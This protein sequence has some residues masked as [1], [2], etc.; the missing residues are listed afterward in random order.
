MFFRY[1]FFSFLIFVSNTAFAQSWFVTGNSAQVCPS[2]SEKP[3]AKV[4]CDSDGSLYLFV[5]EQELRGSGRRHM[6]V[7]RYGTMW[8]DPN[9]PEDDYLKFS[10]DGHTADALG[11]FK[12]GSSFSLSSGSFKRIYSLKGSSKAIS[13]VQETCSRMARENAPAPDTFSGRRTRYSDEAS[14]DFEIGTITEGE[15]KPTAQMDLPGYDLRSGLDDP[16]LNNLSP[17]QC[18]ALCLVTER[19]TAYTLNN[20]NGTVFG[21][22]IRGGEGTCFLKERPQRAVRFRGV[23]SAEMVGSW[24][25]IL[26]PPT[27]G[28]GLTVRSDA[29]PR[30]DEPIISFTDRIREISRPIANSCQREREWAEDLGSGMRLWIDADAANV[31][32]SAIVTWVG[33]ELEHRVPVWVIVSIDK[34][35]RFGGDGFF[36]LGPNSANPFGIQAGQGQQRA[37]TA[38]HARGAAKAGSIKILPLESGKLEVR[39]QVVSYLRNCEEELILKSEIFSLDVAPGEPTVVLPDRMPP[40]D[41]LFTVQLEQFDRVVEFN[42]TR[43]RILHE[44]GSEILNRAGA[45]VSF[46][47]TSRFMSTVHNDKLDIVDVVDGMTIATMDLGTLFWGLDDGLVMTSVVPWGEVSLVSTLGAPL[48]VMEQV[49]GPSCCHASPESTTVFISLE[50][51]AFGIWGS[52]GHY[53]GSLQAPDYRHAESPR[54]ALSSS[55]TGSRPLAERVFASMGPVAPIS[56][57]AG[58]NIPGGLQVT[59]SHEDMSFTENGIHRLQVRNERIAERL[60]ASGLKWSSK[61]QAHAEGGR[62]LPFQLERVG[63][64]LRQMG[65]GKVV[66]ETNSGV[67][68]VQELEAMNQH[69]VTRFAESLRAGGWDFDWSD[70]GPEAT[71]NGPGECYHMDLDQ[72]NEDWPKPY[73]VRDLARLIQIPT[74]EGDIWISQS[75]CTAGATFG[76]L[77]PTTALYIHDIPAG[78]PSGR[79][80][81]FRD[82]SFFFEN[83]PYPL[84]NDHPFVAKADSSYVLL[85]AP[86]R[87]RAGVYDREAAKMV[88]T[89]VALRNG[90]MMV[91]AYLTADAKNLVQENSDGSFEIYRLSDGE[92]VLRGRI[93]DGEVAIWTDDFRYDATAE[94]AS[95][96]DIRF[97]GLHEEF[98]LDRF[99]TGVREIGLANRVSNGQRI[100]S[101]GKLTVP[102]ALSGS[103]TASTQNVEVALEL[104]PTR[105]AQFVEIYQEGVL[106]DTLLIT[107]QNLEATVARVKGARWISA[108][109]RDGAGIASNDLTFDVGVDLRGKGEVRGL[110]I[111]VDRYSDDRLA[112]LNYAKSDVGRVY[113]ALQSDAVRAD[114][115]NVLTKSKASPTSILEAVDELARGLN[116]ED[117]GV[118]FFAGHGL[119][120]ENGNFYFGTPETDLDDLENTALAWT[121]VATSLAQAKG[122]VTVLLDACH[123]GSANGRAFATNDDAVAGLSAIPANVTIFSAAKGRELS[124]ESSTLG[125]GAFSVGIYRVLVEKRE[126]Y[127]TN[128]NGDLERSEFSAGLKSELRSMPEVDQSPWMTNTR[129]VG[130]YALF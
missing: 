82:T 122:R 102:P 56:L 64:S 124:V 73:V 103:I 33:N 47:P 14:I 66:L 59:H 79:A 35:A 26:P 117:Q 52:F 45:G 70:K 2:N 67:R 41:K 96:I 20:G 63:L 108:V 97:A 76:T 11:W 85:F 49:T 95:L 36:A 29:A 21:K 15:F 23:A 112:N 104:D 88:Q 99:E 60:S 42:E 5:E 106:T 90:D 65:S 37:L 107:D 38:L 116:V 53:F 25:T 40:G 71:R 75:W 74:N 87:A 86:S 22:Y 24:N 78:Q 17:E 16:A 100:S 39:A 34:P 130:D 91:D 129:L 126:V 89:F 13:Q 98:S 111:G 44:N 121:D 125:G 32:D 113:E 92:A 61:D 110:L 27:K 12:A 19:C 101:A 119:Q 10:F 128:G 54:G 84:W 9:N 30:P 115:V 81:T 46:S 62:D 123:S 4:T 72:M 118:L 18:A 109:A 51:A 43:I 57:D 3:C 7:P 114:A 48:K 120:D 105:P 55:Q 80:D 8:V 94:A 77:R 31:G 50:N 69:E 28:P 58:F 6:E 127:D 93:A 83:D 68:D 1:I